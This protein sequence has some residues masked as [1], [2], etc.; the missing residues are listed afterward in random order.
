L[1]KKITY[2]PISLEREKKWFSDTHFELPIAI[3]FRY[4]VSIYT[5]VC[6][7]IADGNAPI[8]REQVLLTKKAQMGSQA[9]SSNSFWGKGGEPDF[10]AESF[11]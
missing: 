6:V 9:H 4:I 3:G 8:C 5:C 2:F 11:S 7:C 10:Q 1:A